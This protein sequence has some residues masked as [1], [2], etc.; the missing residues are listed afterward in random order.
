MMFSIDT[1][2]AVDR[3][4]WD[5]YVHASPGSSL[6]HLH[7][8]GEVIEETFGH[9]PTYIAARSAASRIVGVLPVVQLSS[10]L[11]G[12]M[13]ISLPYFN[14]G[15]ICAEQ[16]T[17]RQALFDAAVSLAK[18]G[19]SDFFEV[20]HDQDWREDLPRRTSKVS[21]RLPL[22]ASSDDLWKGLG[23]K[24][25]NQ[26]QRPRKEGMVAQVGRE[27]LLDDFYAVFASNMRD[28]GTPVYP[29]VFFRNILRKFPERTWIATVHRNGQPVAAGF[30]AGFRGS[31]EIPWASALRAFNRLSPNMLLYW[32]CLEFACRNGY[33]VFDF[34][35]STKDEGTYKFKEQWG[36][37]PH[38][39]YWHYWLRRGGD[40]PQVNPSNPKYRAAIE[41]WKR[42]PLPVTTWLGPRIVKNL[43]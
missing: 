41:T 21:M 39:L 23:S 31:L 17:V 25:R 42:L 27:E 14:Y 33:S 1:G 40:I 30:L 13:L 7:G 12:R 11:F 34:G 32:T 36:A 26:V 3:G 18:E 10:R 28:L 35:R 2:S 20:R 29:K 4:S 5:A 22:P 24:L 9:T 37:R 43:P 15:G 8:W 16:D 6:Y 38:P 19:R